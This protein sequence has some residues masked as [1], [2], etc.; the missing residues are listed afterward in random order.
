MIATFTPSELNIAV[1]A[2][3]FKTSIFFILLTFNL[4]NI[5]NFIG[6]PSTFSNGSWF[7]V[8]VHRREKRKQRLRIGNTFSKQKP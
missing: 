2:G 4:L 3:A 5:D 7:P 1:L 6:V 8:N